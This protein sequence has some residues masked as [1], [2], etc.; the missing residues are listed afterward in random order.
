MQVSGFFF[1][2]GERKCF[3]FFIFARFKVVL[4]SIRLEKVT[5]G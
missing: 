2:R 4:E 5:V 3:F 1:I